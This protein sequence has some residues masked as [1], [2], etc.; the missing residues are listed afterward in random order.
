MMSSVKSA[1]ITFPPD[2][3]AVLQLMQKIKD[4]DQVD[5]RLWYFV[6][7]YI[8]HYLVTLRELI[9][10]TNF[11]HTPNIKQT[12]EKGVTAVDWCYNRKDKFATALD[13]YVLYLDYATNSKDF[14]GEK[15]SIYTNK[16]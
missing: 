9:I 12:F 11:I 8:Y 7:E 14:L 5:Y 1:Q 4:F 15:L 16:K 13:G 2:V 10:T 6:A 3:D